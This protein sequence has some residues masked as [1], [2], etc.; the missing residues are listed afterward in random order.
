MK[1]G[2]EEVCFLAIQKVFL[3]L[4]LFMI[5]Q[6]NKLVQDLHNKQGGKLY[7]KFY[8]LI[9]KNECYGL[10]CLLFAI[11]V[12]SAARKDLSG[13][14]ARKRTRVVMDTETKQLTLRKVELITQAVLFPFSAH[15]FSRTVLFLYFGLENQ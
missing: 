2:F 4:K 6:E 1:L 3:G 15:G 9:M 10:I 7:G 8:K 11:M 12:T 14:T 13:R 5:T